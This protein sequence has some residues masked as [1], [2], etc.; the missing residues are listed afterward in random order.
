MIIIVGKKDI[1]FMQLD[2]SG[3][4]KKTWL[5]LLLNKHFN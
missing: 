2:Q 4:L 5:L 3:R 1:L